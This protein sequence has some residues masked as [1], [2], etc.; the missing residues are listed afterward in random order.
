MVDRHVGEAA[1]LRAVIEKVRRAD[2]IEPALRPRIAHVKRAKCDEL[3]RLGNGSG[4]SRTALT[5]LKIAVFAPMPIA[6][7]SSAAIVKLG[8]FQ[9][10]RNAKRSSVME[11]GD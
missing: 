3:L 11:A 8:D 6:R 1:V 4:F 5:T 9:S 2:G 7:A 10:W